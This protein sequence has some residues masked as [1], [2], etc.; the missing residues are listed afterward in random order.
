MG[1]ISAASHLYVKDGRLLPQLSEL[2]VSSVAP[3]SRQ[4][5]EPIDFRRAPRVVPVSQ[6]HLVH[7]GLCETHRLWQRDSPQQQ[8]AVAWRLREDKAQVG[9]GGVGVGEL[10]VVGGD[11]L[12]GAILQAE[13]G[14]AVECGRDAVAVLNR[15]VE[16][17]AAGRDAVR[18]NET[19]EAKTHAVRNK[20]IKQQP[21]Y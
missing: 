16:D 19:A 17:A 10:Q 21:N 3:I 12:G 18:H 4:E 9:G 13:A 1:L 11:G 5:V 6:V 7:I 8:L 14:V 15:E 20:S 2:Q